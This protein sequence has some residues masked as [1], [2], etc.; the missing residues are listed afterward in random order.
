MTE[1]V[2][3]KIRLVTGSY[4]GLPVM[5][6]GEMLPGHARLDV[7]AGARRWRLQR[8]SPVAELI[9]YTELFS[10]ATKTKPPTAIGEP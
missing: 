8:I 2:T 9:L 5:P 1:L 3:T 10:V 6:L 7:G 4:A